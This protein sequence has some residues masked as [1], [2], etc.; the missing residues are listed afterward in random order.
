MNKLFRLV[1]SPINSSIQEV[2][3]SELSEKLLSQDVIT[4]ND[5]DAVFNPTDYLI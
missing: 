4:F 3:I 5:I 1:H 2:N